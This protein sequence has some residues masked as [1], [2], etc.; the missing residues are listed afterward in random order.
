MAAIIVHNPL[1]ETTEISQLCDSRMIY[2]EVLKKEGGFIVANLYFQFN[3]EIE[4]YINKI[5]QI[6][7]QHSVKPIIIT[8]DTNAKSTLWHSDTTDERGEKLSDLF[9]E[10]DLEVCNKQSPTPT[11]HNRAAHSSNI[12]VTVE[13]AS[14][15][16]FVKNWEVTDNQTL[17]NNNIIKFEIDMNKNI[18]ELEH[19]IDTY[20]N[21][22]TVD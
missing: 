13:N 16:D 20:Y 17:S 9:Q 10:L 4:P 21:P 2:V 14:A 7:D 19:S 3:E 5:R 15:I 18:N 8:M 12:D 11:F 22:K 1:I 6:I